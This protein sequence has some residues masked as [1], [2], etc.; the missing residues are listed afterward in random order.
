MEL[1]LRERGVLD[2]AQHHWDVRREIASQSS[3]GQVLIGCSQ[4]LKASP[5]LR[6][7]GRWFLAP[8]SY[9]SPLPLVLPHRHGLTVDEELP[10]VVWRDGC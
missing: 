10:E 5:S 1:L 9:T 4:L 8:D 3:W 2:Q 6:S 7:P